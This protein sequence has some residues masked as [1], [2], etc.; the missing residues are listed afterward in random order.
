MI[1]WE[2]RRKEYDSG[3]FRRKIIERKA[4]G[5]FSDYIKLECGHET[6]VGRGGS[7]GK[8]G[9]LDCVECAKKAK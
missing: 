2:Q 1:D 4:K 8:D 6:D 5:L 3:K 7:L 9:Y